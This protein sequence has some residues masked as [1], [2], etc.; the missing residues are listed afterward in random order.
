MILRRV[1]EH[2]KQQHWTAVALDFVIVVMGVFIGMQVNN[3]NA[4]RA[5]RVQ[6]KVIL[7]RLSED[8]RELVDK[9]DAYLKRS[10]QQRQL[11]ALW[12]DASESGKLHDM[13]DLRRLVLGFYEK[14]DPDYAR[15]LAKQ[16]ISVIFTVP[17]GRAK[18]PQ[19]SVTFQQLVTSGELNLVRSEP[20]RR[21]LMQYDAQRQTATET[22]ASN[23]ALAT[24]AIGAAFF[25][26]AFQSGSPGS[27]QVLDAALADPTFNAGLRTAYGVRK[28]N[29]D[30][31]ETALHRAKDV[32]D[33]LEKQKARKQ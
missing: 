17:L 32:L 31:Y 3:W 5:D 26:A 28:Y 13:Q 4:A 30:W 15:Q 22:I 11:E 33:L 2:V 8:F 12:I 21:A 23:W 6:E 25:R 14:Q 20:L 10:A 19:V 16:D 24:P 29:D 18:T 7:T 9:G 1:I 27:E